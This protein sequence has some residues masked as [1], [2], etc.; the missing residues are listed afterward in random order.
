[1]IYLI[2][3]YLTSFLFD[4]ALAKT[5]FF[6]FVLMMCIFQ[7]FFCT[8]LEIHKLYICTTLLAYWAT[9]YYHSNAC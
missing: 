9:V 1:M 2:R 6:T 5:W 4:R 7:M 8:I 3:A